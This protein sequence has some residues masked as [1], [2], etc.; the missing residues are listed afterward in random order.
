[1]RAGRTAIHWDTCWSSV[2]LKNGPCDMNP[3]WSSA[4]RDAACWK[5]AYNQFGMD[6]ILWEGLQAG[7]GAENDHEGEAQMKCYGLT[8]IP[9]PYSL[10]LLRDRSYKMV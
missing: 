10:V 5:Q 8:A 7:A 1:M 2:V 6:D 9:I 3:C 4:W